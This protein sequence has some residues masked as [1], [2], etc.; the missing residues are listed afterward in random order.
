MGGT[1]V[2]VSILSYDT[3]YSLIIMGMVKKC[4]VVQRGSW[5]LLFSPCV[6]VLFECPVKELHECAELGRQAASF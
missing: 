4:Q 5:G 2:P 3:N 1:A 6:V